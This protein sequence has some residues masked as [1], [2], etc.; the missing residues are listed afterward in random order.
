MAPASSDVATI[1]SG[2]TATARVGDANA[3]SD[4]TPPV[5]TAS[6]TLAQKMY[7]DQAASAQ[8]GGEAASGGRQ[9]GGDDALDAEFEEVDDDKRK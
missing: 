1:P 7:E 8:G 2:P 4:T 6:A 5:G 3:T 9:E